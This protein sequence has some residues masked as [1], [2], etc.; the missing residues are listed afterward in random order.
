MIY[1]VKLKDGTIFVGNRTIL[2][3]LDEGFFDKRFKVLHSGGIPTGTTIIVPNSAISYMI[4]EKKWKSRSSVE[5]L[6]EGG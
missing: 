1:T 2:N 3:K 6:K 5:F 4:K